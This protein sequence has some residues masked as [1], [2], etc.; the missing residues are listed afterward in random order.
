MHRGGAHVLR[1]LVLHGP[2]L[3]LLGLRE[4]EIYGSTTLAEVD[5]SL[6]QLADKLSVGIEIQQ[7]NHEGALVD[8]IQ[9]ARGVFDGIVLNPGAYTH[10]SLAIRDAL[11]AGG[12]PAVEVHVSNPYAREP[13]R[14][15]STIGDIVRGRVMGFGPQG[16][17]LGLEGLVGILRQ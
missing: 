1:V 4:P 9:A 5:A 3:N 17:L 16:Y 10:T 13:F 14:H 11:S 6:V 8:K 12:L 15:T 2:N 7:S